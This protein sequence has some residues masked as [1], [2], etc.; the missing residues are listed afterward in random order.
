MRSCVACFAFFLVLPFFAHSDS[1]SVYSTSG[2][3][4]VSNSGSN[5]S[6]VR[7]AST[8][9]SAD[10]FSQSMAVGQSFG[11]PTYSVHRSFLAFDTTSIPSTAAIDSATLYIYKSIMFTSGRDFPIVVTSATNASTAQLST[12][13]Y[14]QVSTL[15]GAT[16]WANSLASGAYTAIPLGITGI[17]FINK[18]G[19]TKLALRSRYD[20]VS[21]A[22]LLGEWGTVYSRN[23]TDVTRRPKLV[24]EYTPTPSHDLRIDAVSIRDYYGH[25][26][27][28]TP[29]VGASV[30]FQAVCSSASAGTP[31]FRNTCVRDGVTM[32]DQSTN[33]PVAGS[34]TLDTRVGGPWV[35]TSGSHSFTW[36]L[37]VDSDVAETNEGNNT[38]GDSWST[39]SPSLTV[40]YPNGGESLTKGQPYYVTW[41]NSNYGGNVYVELYRNGAFQETITGSVLSSSESVYWIVQTSLPSDSTYRIRVGPVGGG[42]GYDESN[43]NFAIGTQVAPSVQVI[44]S[45]GVRGTTFQ[46][47]GSGFTPNA[48]ATLHFRYP[49][50]T[51]QTVAGK[52]TDSNGAYSHNWPAPQGAQLGTYEYW[53]VDDTTSTSSN[54]VIFTVE[55]GVPILS[56]LYRL[57]KEDSGKRDHFYTLDAS[58]RDL[59]VSSEDYKDE[60]VEGYLSARPFDGGTPLFQLFLSAEDSHYYTIDQGERDAKIAQGYVYERDVGY[61]FTLPEIG[62]VKLNRMHQVT[63][64]PYHYFMCIRNDEYAAVLDGDFG[65]YE[66]LQFAGYVSPNGQRESY[67]QTKHQGNVAGVDTG[68]GAFRHFVSNTGLSLSGRGPQLSFRHYYN[69]LNAL[70]VPMGRGWSHSLYIFAIESSDGDVL[71]RWGDGS[72]SV[73]TYN[74]SGYDPVPGN[75]YEIVRIDDGINEGYDVTSKDQTVFAFRKL[76]T[77]PPPGSEIFVP[78]ILP[79]WIRDRHGNQLDLSYDAAYG[80]LTFARDDAGRRFDFSYDTELRVVEVADS[81]ITRSVQFTYHP[82]G[83]LATY[84]DA[85]GKV[86]QYDYDSNNRLVEITY[87]RLNTVSVA[88]DADWRSSTVQFSGETDPTAI[89]YPSNNLRTITDPRGETWQL[90]HV[91][92]NL[93]QILDPLSN[94][95]DLEYLNG[96]NPF[97]PTQVVDLRSNTWQFEYDG[98]GNLTK[99]TDPLGA[100]EE[101][102]YDT[103]NNLQWRREFRMSVGPI[104][105]TDFTYDA[106]GNLLLDIDNAESENTHF[107]YNAFGQIE[108]IRD[109]NLNT[110]NISYDT[111]GNLD[112]VTD[113]LSNVSDSD[114]DA[115]GRLTKLTDAELKVTDY[116]YDTNDNLTRIV[117]EE[118]QEIQHRYDDNGNLDR[119]RAINGAQLQDTVYTYDSADRLSTVTD[120]LSHVTTYGYNNDGELV[121]RLDA[122]NDTT[123]YAYDEN[124]RL[125]R[126]DYPGGESI[127]F[128]RNEVGQITNANRLGLGSTSLAY[129][130]VGRLISSTDPYGQTVSYT[131]HPDSQRETVVYPGAKTVSYAYDAVNRLTDVDDW[132]SSAL[133]YDYDNAGNLTDQVNPNGTYSEFA[134]DTAARLTDISHRESDST[135]FASY[136]FTLNGVG[137]PSQFTTLDPIEPI[138]LG[139]NVTYTSGQ[140]NQLLSETGGVNYGY[141]DKGNRTSKIDGAV[142]TNYTYDFENRLSQV[143]NT[144]GTI[145]DHVYDALGNRI[146]KIEDGTTTRYVLDL[147][148]TMSQAVM[149]TDEL[150]AVDAY[151]VYGQGLVAQITSGNVRYAYHSD[152]VGSVVAMTDSAESL[153]NRYAYSPFGIVLAADESGP[154]N[155]FQYVGQFGVMSDIHDL[156][157]MRARFYD[158][159][160]G[161]FLNRDP[162][163]FE[164]GDWN[165]Y[166]YAGGN[167]I[168]QIDPSGNSPATYFLGKYSAIQWLIESQEDQLGEALYQWVYSDGIYSEESDEILARLQT[169]FEGIKSRA[170]TVMEITNQVLWVGKLK[171][172]SSEN[173]KTFLGGLKAIRLY[174]KPGV[175]IYGYGQKKMFPDDPVTKWTQLAV[176]LW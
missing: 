158:Q 28:T 119:V 53:S 48:T 146:A 62:L 169:G 27:Y 33:R 87:P 156:T 96:N 109:G 34:F 159:K 5:Y 66:A 115:A 63:D 123:S 52:A 117:G 88:Y 20:I 18:G 140:D 64:S 49:D 30:Y 167:S 43:A 164:G 93:T 151:Y 42:F 55:A 113:P 3:G 175:K 170:D 21:S 108:S 116:E 160:A 73:F 75:Y 40:T 157:F 162:I 126:T 26:T 173:P 143:S 19:A 6:T 61:V 103:K 152:Q 132:A 131:Y 11:A 114:Y 163:G 138:L 13:D 57:Y 128:V 147:S 25:Q 99:R 168:A 70:S 16:V 45:S 68:T 31:T 134:Y 90:T 130:A 84:V 120:P 98:N 86:T 95:S 79:V 89:T 91:D 135:P 94:S 176:S 35:V 139:S 153:V 92:G 39:G 171:K 161:R 38:G 12:S 102:D 104:H 97:K 44:P 141:D 4:Q 10:Y 81:A 22:P 69:S 124:G 107:G 9:D 144:S 129:D 8:G 32:H 17:E 165:L 133:S 172:L 51:Q 74:G 46:Q 83:N 150:A 37:D 50:L 149:E 77:S 14:D 111:N 7:G 15:A 71:I 67:D 78:S 112:R 155:P 127:V 142:T 76:S 136:A 1:L 24:I 23:A 54:T 121:S 85:R 80:T 2:D 137:N 47:P 82:S 60:G 125:E 101:F 65:T 36:T 110:T 122:N 118:N 100:F 106:G 56:P 174:S 29:P 105:Q 154:A 41:S 72:E 166:A 59:K 58:E 148:G 145:V